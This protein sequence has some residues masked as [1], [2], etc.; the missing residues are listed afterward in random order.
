[1]ASLHIEALPLL[2]NCAA[3][4]THAPLPACVNRTAQVSVV[5]VCVARLHWWSFHLL[6]EHLLMMRRMCLAMWVSLWYC[7]AVAASA[8]LR[9][10]F[11]MAVTCAVVRRQGLVVCESQ[12]L[13]VG[14]HD[15]STNAASQG[16]HP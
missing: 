5:V 2:S 4:S 15:G 3:A 13:R 10:W 11:S 7:F 6:L 1:M 9:P 16:V 8:S 12:S 14:V